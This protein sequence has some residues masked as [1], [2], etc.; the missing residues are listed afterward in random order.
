MD[1]VTHARAVV[2]WIIIPKDDELLPLANRHLLYVRHEVVR[3]AL[4]VLPDA[5]GG[6]GADGV[7]VAQQAD[8]E[9]VLGLGAGHRAGLSNVGKDLLVEELGGAVRV[10]RAGGEG[11]VDGD[12]RRLAVDGGGGGENNVAAAGSL[13]R[14]EQV[15]R[16]L[17]VHLV[18]EQRLR[19]TLAHSFETRKM[20]H[21]RDAMLAEDIRERSLVADIHLVE[22][23][24]ASC[25]LLD[26]A[27]A[28]LVRVAEVVDHH[29]LV[30]FLDE[31]K[32]G[33]G[34]NIPNA[35]RDEHF[36]PCTTPKPAA[37]GACAQR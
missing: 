10:G 6:V 3:H 33:V 15:K 5:S 14:L 25:Q 9:L 32:D 24:A 8:V 26:T 27:Q 1:V 12:A 29:Y 31:L 37:N 7:K 19:D 20:H 28:L 21:S 17:D 11:L 13:H 16:A 18:V 35:A 30:A 23:H 2:C 22:G 36:L 4:W 34:A